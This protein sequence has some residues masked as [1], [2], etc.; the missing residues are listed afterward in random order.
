VRILRCKHRLARTLV[1]FAVSGGRKLVAT[2]SLLPGSAREAELAADRQEAVARK[3]SIGCR[4]ESACHCAVH[5]QQCK[6]QE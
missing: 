6:L 3:H 1:R 4:C 2:L 5:C